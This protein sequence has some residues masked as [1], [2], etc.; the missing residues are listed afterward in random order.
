MAQNKRLLFCGL[1][2]GTV[3]IYPLALPQE[4]LCLPPPESLSRVLCLAV[5][6]QE[7]HMAVAYE[8]SICLF[9][10]TTRD[11]FPAVEGP[12]QRLPLSLLH[13]PLSSMALLSDRRLLY[14]TSCGEVRFHDFCNGSSSDLEAHRGRVTCVTVSNWGTRALVGSEDAVLRLWSLSPLVLDHT[15]EYKVDVFPTRYFTF[16][17]I[18]IHTG[19]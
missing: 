14:G 12:L 19:I 8:D 2:T 16:L 3:L 17:Y 6:S 15:M 11:S 9:E 4:T 13:A 5:S 7:K 18:H 10:I 1:N